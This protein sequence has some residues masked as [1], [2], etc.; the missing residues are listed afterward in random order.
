MS[1]TATFNRFE[2]DLPDEAVADC[3]HQGDCDGD[4]AYWEPHITIEA[5]PDQIRAELREYGAWDADE[6]ADDEANRRR[7]I[8]CAACNIKEESRA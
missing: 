5:T 6:L 4:V 7:I 2:I 8:W 1:K 3:S